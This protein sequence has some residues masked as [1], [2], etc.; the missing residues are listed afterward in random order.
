MA[1]LSD[2]KIRAAKPRAKPYKLYDESGLFFIIR[3][4]GARWGRIKYRWRGREGTLSAGV[5]P[6]VGLAAMRERAAEVA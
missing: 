5:Y 4:D 2:T 1:K 3:P 6:L